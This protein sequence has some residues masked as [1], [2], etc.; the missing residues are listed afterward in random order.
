MDAIQA[1][2]EYKEQ[3]VNSHNGFG[4]LADLG[5]KDLDD[6][7]DLPP[8]DTNDMNL[9]DHIPTPLEIKI[10]REKTFADDNDS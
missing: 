6:L 5:D 9:E 1:E 2:G 10:S 7:Q 8:S 3:P 4:V